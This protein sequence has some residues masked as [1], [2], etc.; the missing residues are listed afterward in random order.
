MGA[1]TSKTLRL[2]R[3]ALQIFES[4]CYQLHP[5]ELWLCTDTNLFVDPLFANPWF[6]P[7][8]IRTSQASNCHR[9]PDGLLVGPLFFALP[10]KN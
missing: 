9:H 3:T 5:A 10:L 7:Q 1:G 6:P 8:K 4:R 2:T